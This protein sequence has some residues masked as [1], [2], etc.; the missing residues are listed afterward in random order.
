MY[1]QKYKPY[2]SNTTKLEE[3]SKFYQ[4]SV[5]AQADSQNINLKCA[6][7]TTSSENRSDFQRGSQLTTTPV[8]VGT[9]TASATV[10]IQIIINIGPQLSNPISDISRKILVSLL[11]GCA[12]EIAK[13]SLL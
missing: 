6:C 1:L 2:I 8:G 12:C 10:N 7:L 5:A 3:F 13:Y 9:E 11:S 4:K